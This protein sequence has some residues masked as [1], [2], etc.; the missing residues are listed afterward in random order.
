MASY[1]V[2][3]RS[4][5]NAGIHHQSSASGAIFD[6]TDDEESEEDPTEHSD[7]EPA[8]KHSV[9]ASVV[10]ELPGRISK[11]PVEKVKYGAGY[12]YGVPGWFEKLYSYVYK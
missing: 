7:Y 9:T 8:T 5:T 10:R 11:M 3:D 2:N 6:L 12:N 1:D 4:R